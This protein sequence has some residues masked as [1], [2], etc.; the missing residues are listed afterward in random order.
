MLDFGPQTKILVSSTFS[1]HAAEQLE[2]SILS[3]HQEA[4]TTIPVKRC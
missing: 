1:I 4:R 2:V 3:I